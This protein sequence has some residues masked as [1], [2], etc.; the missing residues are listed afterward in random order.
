MTMFKRF[1]VA[2]GTALLLVMATACSNQADNVRRAESF[3]TLLFIAA[4]D[5]VTSAPDCSTGAKVCID[6][7]K[8]DMIAKY[9]K[10]LHDGTVA[11]REAADSGQNTTVVQGLVASAVAAEAAL[12][13]LVPDEFKS[14]AGVD[15][16]H[17]VSAADILN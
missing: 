2:I 6:Q 14:E 15:I 17:A 8:K 5:Y 1:G 13:V 4:D 12:N 7:G 3:Q 11:A 10:A 16:N 9:S